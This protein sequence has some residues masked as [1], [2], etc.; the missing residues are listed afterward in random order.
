MEKKNCCTQ[1]GDA[2]K[3]R[4]PSTEKR[5]L[6]SRYH[7]P[8]IDRRF[9][10]SRLRFQ[11]SPPLRLLLSQSRQRPRFDGTAEQILRQS[12]SQLCR[13]QRRARP[14][15][16]CVSLVGPQPRLYVWVTLMLF[17]WRGKKPAEGVAE[18]R[19]SW[20]VHKSHLARFGGSSKSRYL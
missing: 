3:H 2:H 20:G 10:G 18:K 6:D 5:V 11:R 14:R 13:H 15:K 16:I 17:R 19:P 1:D 8:K 4:A 9:G 12:L 7:T